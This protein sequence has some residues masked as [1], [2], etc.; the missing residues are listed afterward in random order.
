MEQTILPRH[1]LELR[2][3]GDAP[4]GLKEKFVST[5][6]AGNAEEQEI[7][8]FTR[9][10]AMWVWPP[11]VSILSIS[12]LFRLANEFDLVST[13][14]PDPMPGLF[15]QMLEPGGWLL[16]FISVFLVVFVRRVKIPA[17]EPRKITLA[18]HSIDLFRLA[19]A[20]FFFIY[21]YIVAVNLVPLPDQAPRI[22]FKGVFCVTAGMVIAWQCLVG[23]YRLFLVATWLFILWV[24]LP[25][26]Q[27]RITF[28]EMMLEP[29]SITTV[30]HYALGLVLLLLLS[31]RALQTFS[32][33]AGEYQPQRPML[34]R[35]GLP[36]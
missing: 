11:I 36:F 34:F 9:A 8:K 13:K 25:Q 23:R 22:D 4:P 29:T 28:L 19:L 24:G 26:M 14:M 27:K 33:A 7:R 21:T 16:F 20:L 32:A 3:N 30:A 18:G 35:K 17:T 5:Y 2:Y 6:D 31:P 12:F 10:T 15:K 1:S